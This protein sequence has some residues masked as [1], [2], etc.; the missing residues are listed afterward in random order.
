[1][2]LR[3]GMATGGA[4][5]RRAAA[6]T[7]P[8]RLSAAG[9]GRTGRHRG[10]CTVPVTA[11]P[12]MVAGVICVG[13]HIGAEERGPLMKSDGTASPILAY[14]HCRNCIRAGNADRVAVGETSEGTVV[15]WCDACDSL[16]LDLGE[17]SGL[18]PPRFDCVHDDA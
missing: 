10:M 2:A 7:G 17:V 14:F 1:M 16:I 6:R 5:A 13:Q 11:T 12:T 4:G 15:V 3:V 18:L 9:G 8:L